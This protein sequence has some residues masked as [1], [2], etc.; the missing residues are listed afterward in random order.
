MRQGDPTSLFLFV[1][2]MEALS[3]LIDKAGE[4]GVFSGI[5]L[6]ND[7]PMLSHLLFADDALIIGDWEESNALHIIRISRCFH[8]CSGLKIN[9]G[10]SNLI[11]IGVDGLEVEALAEVVGCKPDS[12][13]FKY[14]GLKVGA[15]MNRVNNWR[16][17]YDIF[18][19]RRALWKSAMMFIGGRVTLIR[20]VLESL[21]NYYFSLYKAPLKVVKDLES[22][23]KKFLWGAEGRV[24][25]LDG[26]SRLCD[27]FRGSVGRGD[28]ILFWLDPWLMEVP[29]KEAFPKL[30]ALEVV[31]T[32]SVRDWLLGVWLWKHEPDMVD[33]LAELSALKEAMAPDCLI[34]RMDDWK[35]TPD[36]SGLFSV[37]SVKCVL[38][39]VNNNISNYV[40]EWCKWVPIKC[41]V[42][43]WR[44]ELNR[45]PT[46]DALRR[47]GIVV[48]DEAC[49]L[50]KLEIESVEHLFASCVTAVVLWQKISRWLSNS[51]HLCIF[52]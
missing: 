13:P 16:P 15:N 37:S 41:N 5:K 47:R 29:L 35:R 14:L 44:A 4:A 7:G 51:S 26:I 18:E 42:F 30:F 9:L 10:K 21:P 52:I 49:P 32:C 12:L 27:C 28:N 48:G 50:C 22:L 19:S 38:E 36:H 40:V 31:K 45:I 24:R 33:E 23:I 2:V 43:I 6:P 25:L 3:R 17:V 46:A 1:A 20:S 39:G 8:V 11:G 34:D